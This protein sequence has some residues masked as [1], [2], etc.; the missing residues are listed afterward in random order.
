MQEDEAGGERTPEQKS[1]G[2]REAQ[3][4]KRE[5]EAESEKQRTA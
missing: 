1:E 4:E 3:D 5:K 2:D